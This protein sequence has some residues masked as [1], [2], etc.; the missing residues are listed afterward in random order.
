MLNLGPASI[1]ISVVFLRT[2]RDFRT[3]CNVEYLYANR[4]HQKSPS[5]ATDHL[6]T[7]R[8]SPGTD[9]L[10]RPHTSSTTSLPQGRTASSLRAP[11]P[12]STNSL[13]PRLRVRLE[14]NH[15]LS[16]RRPTSQASQLDRPGQPELTEA[17]P[18]PQS[19]PKGP[20]SFFFGSD[21]ESANF[22]DRPSPGGAVPLV[23]AVSYRDDLPQTAIRD[24]R[25]PA[26]QSP[27]ARRAGCRAAKVEYSANC[28]PGPTEP[29][30]GPAKP[31][32]QP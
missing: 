16:P 24:L 31:A 14:S 29:K 18:P 13:L 6:P 22:F 3:P 19:R 1:T 21:P 17:T 15:R 23:R 26:S 8:R 9:P 10:G 25:A 28:S 12:R 32:H 20:A 27:I 4:E 30:E 7:V 5:P 11:T 2:S